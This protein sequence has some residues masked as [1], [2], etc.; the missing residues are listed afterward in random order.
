MAAT[1]GAR[2]MA[3]DL[4][5]M[6]TRIQNDDGNWLAGDLGRV[7]ISQPGHVILPLDVAT[8]VNCATLAFDAPVH[9]SRH[10]GKVRN[11]VCERYVRNLFTMADH[12]DRLEPDDIR[13]PVNQRVGSYALHMAAFGFRQAMIRGKVVEMSVEPP[14]G[15]W[16][17]MV[18]PKA[19]DDRA[20]Y[21]TILEDRR[22]WPIKWLFPQSDLEILE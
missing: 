10:D 12:C 16:C 3:R 9:L 2:I 17:S 19:D 1:A 4:S 6:L 11:A 18:V 5:A 20:V 7:D 13:V 15:D 8:K 21:R 22:P 14:G